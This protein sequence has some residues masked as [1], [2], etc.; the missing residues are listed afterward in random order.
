MAA[1]PTL[2]QASL[3]SSMNA[4]GMGEEYAAMQADKVMLERHLEYLKDSPGK[5]MIESMARFLV[6]HHPSAPQISPSKQAEWLHFPGGHV[7]SAK[8]DITVGQYLTEGVNEAIGQPFGSEAVLLCILTPNTKITPQSL[9]F[10]HKTF[11]LVQKSL[12]DLYL[13]PARLIALQVAWAWNVVKPIIP[14]HHTHVPFQLPSHTAPI[15]DAF[16]FNS[17]GERFTF[18][19]QKE[20]MHPRDDLHIYVWQ[21]HLRKRPCIYYSA[22]VILPP[23]TNKSPLHRRLMMLVEPTSLLNRLATHGRHA[24]GASLNTSHCW[25]ATHEVFELIIDL[26]STMVLDLSEFTVDLRDKINNTLFT[27]RNWPTRSKIQYLLHIDDCR[28][29]AIEDIIASE[30]ILYRLKNATDNAR[31]CCQSQLDNQNVKEAVRE[32]QIDLRALREELYMHEKTV[33]TAKGQIIE[34]MSLAQGQRVLI[35]TAAAALF[36]PMSFVAAIFG[37]N[38]TIPLFPKNDTPGPSVSPSPSTS[39]IVTSHPVFITA[40]QESSSIAADAAPDTDQYLWPMTTYFEI[41]LPLTAGTILIPILIGPMIRLLVQTSA[42][43]RPYWRIWLI[44][45]IPMYLAGIATLPLLRTNEICGEAY[46]SLDGSVSHSP[47]TQVTL[48]YKY[49]QIVYW[50]VGYGVIFLLAVYL[51]AVGYSRKRH[52][53]RWTGLLV[54]VL[55]CAIVDPMVFFKS[56][57][58]S[59]FRTNAPWA[60]IP[61]LYAIIS[62]LSLTTRGLNF[63]RRL[64]RLWRRMRRGKEGSNNRFRGNRG[65]KPLNFAG[66]GEYV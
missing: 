27:G 53:V 7:F 9:K 58:Y 46:Q 43:Y 12:P 61:Y 29:R 1:L 59:V 4:L 45:I 5:T 35:L 2:M 50:S 39:N 54:V 15:G 19:W 34:Q 36:I 31:F 48:A 14:Y 10:H 25:N 56:S 8:D 13:A 26:F 60:L 3:S 62:W 37:M 21:P 24:S 6:L 20:V 23:T 28:I 66:P 49:A 33:Y 47:Q 30:T 40:R 55:A 11:E 63:G 16:L 51:V 38:V 65:G 44:M 41:A 52:R 57:Y 22:T 42:H 64:G 17:E 18:R 32:A